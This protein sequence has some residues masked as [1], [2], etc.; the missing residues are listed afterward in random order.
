MNMPVMPKSEN[1][2][3]ESSNSVDSSSPVAASKGAA[4]LE[5]P[6]HDEKPKLETFES[7][8]SN[9]LKMGKPHP[10]IKVMATRKGFYNQRRIVEGTKFSVKSFEELG[11][12][13]KCE[14]ASIEEKRVKVLKEKKM[15]ARK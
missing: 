8:V 1:K 5:A 11:E 7:R 4:T 12:W 9:S 6:M 3:T 10:G 14:D 15:K 2:N 13:M